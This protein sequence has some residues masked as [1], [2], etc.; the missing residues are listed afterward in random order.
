MM[1]PFWQ[2][3]IIHGDDSEIRFVA[4]TSAKRLR[5]NWKAPLASS[6]IARNHK[7]MPQCVADLRN[8]DCS[9]LGGHNY[10]EWRRSTCTIQ[11]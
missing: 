11:S 7:L 5:R 10:R 1:P 6:A 2:Y 4:G 3:L 9:S 8:G